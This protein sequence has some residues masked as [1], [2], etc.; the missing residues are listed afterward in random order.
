MAGKKKPRPSPY[1][2]PSTKKSARISQ[3]KS[4][5]HDK[6]SNIDVGNVATDSIDQ[7]NVDNANSNMSSS[8][9]VNML[10]TT[11]GVPTFE[12]FQKLSETVS[13]LAAIVKSLKSSG[14]NSSSLVDSQSSTLGNNQVD[15]VGVNVA[16][17]TITSLEPLTLNNEA[18]LTH[19]VDRV[20]SDHLATLIESDKTTVSPG[21]YQAPDKPVDLKVT[22][23]IR[24]Q[25]W[26]NQYIDL[27]VLIDP[28]FEKIK[29]GYKLVSE[30]GETLQ[31]A[32]SK[33][34]KLI[35][36]LGQWCSAFQVY[37]TIF[38][39]KYPD[40]LPHLMTYMA[41]I[42]NLAHKNG[43]YLRYDEEF[44]YL[45]QS[46]SL[47]WN[48]THTG[49]LVDCCVH[50]SASKGNS[51]KKQNKQKVKGQWNKNKS[52]DHPNGYCFRYHN[53]GKCGRSNC[54]F[55]HTCYTPECHNSI[56][57]IGQCPNRRNNQLQTGNSTASIGNR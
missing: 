54:N 36:S 45:R 35:T 8:Q 29:P 47:P 20:I 19:Q 4:Q 51:D 18:E 56:H 38:C 50:D 5:Q 14:N 15:S 39:Q 52:S 33:Q 49:L 10:R 34:T 37:I 22:D 2:I 25:I 30:E 7:V 42:K 21:N 48:I 53:Y 16:N 40:Q 1:D 12:Q 55:Q 23:K 32:P 31:L 6:D 41:T 28:S 44:R 11:L 3:R 9:N 17:H 27:S 26:S 24:Q 43:N 46:M 57:P 13:E